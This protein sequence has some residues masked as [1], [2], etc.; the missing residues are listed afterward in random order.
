QHEE[1]A[2]PALAERS[3]TVGRR[4]TSAARTRSPSRYLALRHTKR[5]YWPAVPWPPDS[6][7]ARR[8][9]SSL[10]HRRVGVSAVLPPY[11]ATQLLGRGR[12]ST[13]RRKLPQPVQIRPSAGG[14]LPSREWLPG[15]WVRF[16]GRDGTK[17]RLRSIAPY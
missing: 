12:S 3:L 9:R 10:P 14:K 5:P 2:S 1:L 8:D 13:R 15:A 11:H 17:P 4:A 7:E 16:R 6:A